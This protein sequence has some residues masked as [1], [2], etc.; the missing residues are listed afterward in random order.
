MQPVTDLAPERRELN[1]IQRDRLG[2]IAGIAPAAMDRLTVEEIRVK[3]G[4]QIDPRLLLFRRLTGRVLHQDATGTYRPAAN[5]LVSVQSTLCDLLHVTDVVLGGGWLVVGRV[6][7]E[8]IAEVRTSADGNFGLWIPRFDIESILRW[9][10]AHPA[11]SELIGD[12]RTRRRGAGESVPSTH[13]SEQAAHVERMTD[14][15]DISFQVRFADESGEGEV[16]Y[17]ERFFDVQWSVGAIP[18]VELVASPNPESAPFAIRHG[19]DGFSIHT[20]R[21]RHVAALAPA[22]SRRRAG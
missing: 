3:F 2:E 14:V 4:W 22:D 7:R 18:A 5:A 17:S 10:S 9:R 13:L 16:A 11:F 1:S 19:L 15:P 21:P 12:V 8:Q 20:G 6:R